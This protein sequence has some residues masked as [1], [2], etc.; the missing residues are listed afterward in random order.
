MLITA[1]TIAQ[2]WSFAQGYKIEQEELEYKAKILEF[3]PGY[4][5]S[6]SRMLVETAEG[7]RIIGFKSF[8]AEKI[9]KEFSAGDEVY[10]TT[11]KR[12]VLQNNKKKP[13]DWLERVTR[14]QLNTMSNGMF[15][16]D[17]KSMK[18]PKSKKKSIN[19]FRL[20]IFLEETITRL[21]KVNNE[22]RGFYLE[23]GKLLYGEYAFNMSNHLRDY[24]V[25]DVISFVGYASLLFEGDVRPIPDIVVYSFRHLT[26]VEG[27][28]KSFLVK[29]NY[30]YV[31]L[32]LTTD[33]G[34]IK[35]SFAS[36]NAAKLKGF[37]ETKESVTV[38]YEKNRYALKNNPPGLYAAVLGNDTIRT[39][40]AFYGAPDGKHES[41]SVTYSGQIKKLIKDK[42][43]LLSVIL[44]DDV[45][46]EANTVINQLRHLIKKGI[47]IEVRGEE[48]IKRAGEIYEKD[49]RIIRPESITIKG[50]EYLLNQ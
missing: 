4:T 15:T 13:D 43:N 46:I 25:G 27:R 20:S 10:L 47:T 36:E 41:K 1:L 17:V 38:Y 30:A 8:A 6:Y 22:T 3:Q 34:E 5:F 23:S 44:T 49:Y 19:H 50:K 21:Y 12:K 28:I 2:L 18:Y 39:K 45:L 16:I 31:G 32:T 42:N 40:R 29:Q 48:R 9:L 35:L 33:S 7:K 37:A 26:K 24:R 11:S 14:E